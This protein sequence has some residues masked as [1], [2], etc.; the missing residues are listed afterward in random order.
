VLSDNSGFYCPVESTLPVLVEP[1]EASFEVQGDP[2]DGSVLLVAQPVG[3]YAYV[4]QRNG[5]VIPGGQVIGVNSSNQGTYQVTVRNMNTGCDKQS[6]PQAITITGPI[7]VEVTGTH[8]CETQPFTMTAAAT[9]GVGF[10]WYLNNQ[11][12]TAAQGR[13]DWTDTRPG[14]Y[15]V[16]INNTAGCTDEDEINI[17]LAPFTPP[18]LPTREAICNDPENPDPATQQVTLDPGQGYVSY[19]WFRNNVATGDASSTLTVSEEGTWRVQ[20]TNNFGC[21]GSDQTVVANECIPVIVGPNAFRPSSSLLE[22][23]QWFLITRFLR[24]F[25]IYIFNRWGEMV[26]S[27]TDTQF[28]WNGG[29]NNNMDKPLPAGNYAYVVKFISVY[30]PE[31]G[32]QEQRGGITLMR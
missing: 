16:V 4:W 24:D 18:N 25:E 2:C 3:N 7:Q 23:Q 8:A 17:I 5:T 9:P 31:K 6:T 28:K 13:S 30:S 19:Q 11:L 1:F 26:Y 29:Y 14:V 20:V 32:K 27:S 22:N 15:R 10:N 21:T 12:I